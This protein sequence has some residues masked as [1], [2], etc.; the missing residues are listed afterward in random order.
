MAYVA[1][2][3][4]ALVGV[5][6]SPLGVEYAV[7]IG[8]C[9]YDVAKAKELMKEAGYPTGFETELWSA[10]NHT[11]A[12][13]VTQFLQQQLQQIGIRTKITLLEAGQRGEEG[14]SWQ[15]PGTAPARLDYVGSWPSPRQPDS[16]LRP[17]R[18]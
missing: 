8:E 1:L 6:V 15:D 17:L 12:Q 13:K 18:Y 11:T 10:Y 2:D 9:P 14:E 4:Y 3:G 5:G 7:K 16:P